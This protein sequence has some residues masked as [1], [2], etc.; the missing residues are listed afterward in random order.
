MTVTTAPLP[1]R[2]PRY[3]E[4]TFEFMCRTCG[5]WW[6]LSEEFWI[7]NHGLARCKPCWAEYRRLWERRHRLDPDVV[8]FKRAADRAKYH[9]NREQKKEA[10]RRWR[11]A[12]RERTRAYSREWRLR[13]KEKAA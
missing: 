3:R 10:C 6:E 12:N 8:L 1:L 7:V 11:E 9:V 4:G 2:P 13:Q 5:D